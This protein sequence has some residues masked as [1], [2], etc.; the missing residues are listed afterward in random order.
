MWG[1]SAV[2]QFHLVVKKGL[3]RVDFQFDE[4]RALDSRAREL[5]YTGG[6]ITRG[7]KEKRVIRSTNEILCGGAKLKHPNHQRLSTQKLERPV[8][9]IF[10]P[11]KRGWV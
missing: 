9:S 3:L 10:I 5:L 8:I 2:R 4:Q 1:F 6:D 7:G 11:G